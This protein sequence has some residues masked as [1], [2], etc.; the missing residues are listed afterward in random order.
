M[1]FIVL[2]KEVKLIMVGI[3]VKFCKII[4]EGLNG[5]LFLFLFFLNWFKVLIW[6]FVIIKLFFWWSKDFNKI[7]I[8]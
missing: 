3:F 5:I 6:L 2:C 8:E 7:W 1:L 4:W